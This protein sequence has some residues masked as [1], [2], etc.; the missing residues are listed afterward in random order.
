MRSV[1]LAHG[2]TSNDAWGRSAAA[3]PGDVSFNGSGAQKANQTNRARETGFAESA[4]Q[5]VRIVPIVPAR[6]N[7]VSL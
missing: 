2:A 3:V 7:E 1:L 4:R 5:F 6:E